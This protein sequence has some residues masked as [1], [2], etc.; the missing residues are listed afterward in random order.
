M[1]APR[2]PDFLIIGAMKCATTT[3]H[4][5]LAAQPGLFMPDLKEPNFFSD[6]HQYAKGMDWYRSLFAAAQPED[7]CGEASTHYTKRPTY[8]QACDRLHQALPTAKLIY[9]MRHPVERLISHFI[10]EWTLHNVPKDIHRAIATHPELIAYSQYSRQLRPYLETFGPDRILP[11]FA[12]RLFHDPQAELARICKFIGYPQ[13]PHWVEQTGQTHRSSDRIRRNALVDALVDPPILAALRRRLV[14]KGVRSWVRRQL[15]MQEKPVPNPQCQQQLT[16]IFD[17]DLAV[18]G[19][20]LGVPL[21]C[22]RFKAEVVKA[23]MTWTT[24]TPHPSTP[25]P[26]TLPQEEP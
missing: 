5:Q 20:W 12:E 17:A 10:H 21:S 15:S 25:H 11:V 16:E 4:R 26:S 8:P 2:L 24:A 6:D 13:F 7:Q 9:V 18:L 3:L 14:P 22:D 23:P 19:K 1:T